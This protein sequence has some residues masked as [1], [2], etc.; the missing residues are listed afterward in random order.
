MKNKIFIKS[1]QAITAQETFNT[2]EIFSEIRQDNGKYFEFLQIDH[3][4]FIEARLLRRMSKIIKISLSN[5]VLCLDNAG[6][7]KPDAIITA[8]GLGCLEDTAKFLNQIIHNNEE[9]LNPTPF[10]QST[11][12]TFAG[13]IALLL[14]CKNYNLTFTQKSTSFETALTDAYMFMHEN[15]NANLLLGGIDEMNEEIYDL[16]NTTECARNKNCKLG[17]GSAFFVITGEKND[18]CKVCID[19]FFVKN[20][21]SDIEIEFNAFIERNNLKFDDIDFIV[22][23]LCDC[24]SSIKINNEYLRKLF[25]NSSFAKYKHLTGDYDTAAAFGMFLANNIIENN[26][27]P[28][29]L[30][31]INKN[32]DKYQKGIAFNYTKNKEVSFILLSEC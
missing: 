12:N 13:Q 17:E 7:E 14:N 30:I 16:I 15:P 29:A 21:I 4:Q 10:I 22:S 2:K 24:N 8:T 1:A 20:N 23:G 5:S 28:E 18:K 3:K 19:D 31:H 32:K 25:P 27:I 11:H 9:L 6:I 26:K